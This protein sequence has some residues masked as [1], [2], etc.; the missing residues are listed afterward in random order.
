MRSTGAENAK[1]KSPR[2]S[3]RSRAS[4][5][6]V[7]LSDDRTCVHTVSTGR[8]IWQYAGDPQACSVPWFYSSPLAVQSTSKS[9]K[10]TADAFVKASPP[11]EQWHFLCLPIQPCVQRKPFSSLLHGV[12]LMASLHTGLPKSTA[13]QQFGQQM[14]LKLDE[15]IE[16]RCMEFW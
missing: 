11:E 8:R 1:Y 5:L 9:A 7:K 15:W 6:R 4:L 14:M 2:A 3:G 13:S 12:H 16:S 10:S